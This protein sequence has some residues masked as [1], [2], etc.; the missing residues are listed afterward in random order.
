LV[1][2]ALAANLAMAVVGCVLLVVAAHFYFDRV[3]ATPGIRAEVEDAI[4]WLGLA[5]PLSL[6][7]GVLAGTLQGR[8]RFGVLNVINSASAIGTALLPLA[9]AYFVDPSLPALVIA[10]IAV[11]LAVLLMLAVASAKAVPLLRPARP[12]AA[13][14]RKLASY[15]GWM[16]GTTLLA[17]AVTTVDRFLIGALLGP[18]A[19][20]AYVIP[21]NL[22]SRV[23]LLPAS[24]G[25]ATLPRFA[26]ADREEVQRLQS[27]TLKSLL[28]LL[29]P[30]SVIAIAALAPFLRFWIG[31]GLA[32]IAT[33]IGVILVAGFWVYGVGYVS[34]TVVMGRGRP[35]LLVKLLLAYLIPY[36]A[37]LY[38][39][40]TTMGAVGA[41]I[42]WV[43]KA[44][45]DPLLLFFTKP[46]ASSVAKIFESAAVVL[47]A[48]TVGLI[49]PWTS[50]GY[51]L[52]LAG[53]LALS[54]YLG[55]GI[56][57]PWLRRLLA[58]VQVLART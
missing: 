50:A 37:V 56:L 39:L 52:G 6:T 19:V 26:S 10:T 16:T 14:I 3:S 49:L 55:W 35:D 41:A 27:V 48:M 31:A 5:L 28:A 42:A 38:F 9:T 43:L 18:A 34:S 25:S 23:I 22:V 8:Q 17:P 40:V 1:W 33:P 21:Y 29:T 58:W 2:A 44:A 54:C 32:T 20:S 15:G 11:S 46:D 4:G 13:V 53:L 12:N 51:W 30:I 36:L 47:A 24:L 45:C 7:S 57:S